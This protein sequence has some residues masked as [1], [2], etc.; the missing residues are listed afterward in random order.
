MPPCTVCNHPDMHAIDLAILAGNIHLA[1]LGR[2]F[3]TSKSAMWRHKNHL[4][5]KI[6]LARYRLDNQLRLGL[7]FKLN[8][9]LAEVENASAKAQAA[10]NVDQVFKGAR[11]KN[12][13]L[14]DL[15]KMETP[16]DSLTVYHLL[17]S[18][19]WQNQDTLLPTE[20]AFLA[21]GHQALADAFFHPCP[22]P[23]PDWTDA[24]DDEDESCVG[25]ESDAHPAVW[26]SSATAARINPGE[27]PSA[28]PARRQRDRSATEARR[29]RQNRA[30][31]R[32]IISNLK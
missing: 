18:P 14:R 27:S 9:T 23:S 25:R 16:G 19:Q 1:A 28:T 3:G 24:D 10:D 31:C 8:Q 13:L 2:K 6:T 21:R 5:E 20:P 32:K 15:G 22:D 7:L 26:A 11:V 4:E 12:R 29:K 17:T 30:P